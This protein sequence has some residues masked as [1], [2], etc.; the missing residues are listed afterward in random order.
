MFKEN[1]IFYKYLWCNLYRSNCFFASPVCS[2]KTYYS[3]SMYRLC[4]ST[5]ISWRKI[6]FKH[7]FYDM[8]WRKHPV[9]LCLVHSSLR[10]LQTD[11]LLWCTPLKK[12][13]TYILRTYNT[14]GYSVPFV[15]RL[16]VCNNQQSTVHSHLVVTPPGVT[17]SKRLF[18]W[19]Q[20]LDDK[21]AFNCRHYAHERKRH[22]TVWRQWIKVNDHLCWRVE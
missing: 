5:E 17:T 4:H 8:S 9:L 18:L 3:F 16:E 6:I 12:I 1:N 15:T 22:F 11:I 10:Y 20:A 14:S 7:P 21:R 19:Q 13:Y 2:F